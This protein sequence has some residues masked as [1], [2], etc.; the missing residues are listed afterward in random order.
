MKEFPNFSLKEGSKVKIYLRSGNEIKA[1][2]G[3]FKG[4]SDT[5]QPLLYLADK[6][7]NYLTQDYYVYNGVMKLKTYL[8]QGDPAREILDLAKATNP[9]LIVIGNRKRGFLRGVFQS[10]GG[11]R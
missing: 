3:E 7:K 10:K 5:F 11:T 9:D 4:L 2:E 8:K 6:D 1:L